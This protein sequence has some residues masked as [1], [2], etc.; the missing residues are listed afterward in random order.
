MQGKLLV[1][2]TASLPINQQKM[3]LTKKLEKEI[4]QVRNACWHSYLKGDMKTFS[5]FPD[6]D[7]KVTGS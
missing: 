7:F 1:L 6:D 3:T 5:S 2:S 4:M